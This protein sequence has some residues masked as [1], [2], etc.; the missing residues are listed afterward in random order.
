M[1]FRL[2]I[3]NKKQGGAPEEAM[4]ESKPVGVLA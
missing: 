3:F 1:I 2:G 4:A